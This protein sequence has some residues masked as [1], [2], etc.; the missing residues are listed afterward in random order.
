MPGKRIEFAWVV[1][2][3]LRSLPLV[4]TSRLVA[5]LHKERQPFGRE[6][7]P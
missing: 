1:L 7:A 4:S 3:V 5:D 6:D 2:L